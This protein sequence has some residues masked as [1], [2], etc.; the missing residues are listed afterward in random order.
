MNM[1]RNPFIFEGQVVSNDDPDQMGRVKVWIQA[2]DGEVFEVD[3]LPWAEYASML[4]GFTVEMPGGTDNTKNHSHA[5]YG[6]W[7]IPKMGATVY[8]FCLGGDPSRRVYFASS[9]RLH[10]NRSMPAGRNADGFG[11]PGPWG[12]AGDGNGTLIPIEPAFSNLRD[13]FQNKVTDSEAITRGTYE[14]MAAQ[15]LFDKDGKEGYSKTPLAGENYLDPQTYCFVTPGRHALIF[16]DDPKYARVRVKTAEGHQIILDDVNERIYV[17]TAK[18]KSWIEMDL[19]GHVHI[20]GN[21]NV[22]VRSGKD[23]NFTADG[24][25]NLEAGKGFN[26]KARG[27]DIRMATAKQL[28][29]HAVGAA[30]IAACGNI[31]IDG[32][33]AIKIAS[34]DDTDFKVGGDWTCNAERGVDFKYGEKLRFDGNLVHLSG[35]GSR[36]AKKAEC[37]KQPDSPS[38]VPGHEPWRRP[39]GEGQR[40]KNWK[41]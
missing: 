22:S 29:V 32:E 33:A 20:F 16:Q 31:N 10:R 24:N 2:L 12:D 11:K 23:I 19:D 18:G 21:S 37:P 1:S 34:A 6:M 26:L 15:P 35:A 9:W 4:S 17:S 5:A 25:I 14:R 13:Q 36:T 39:K 28:H 8:V 27:G 41:A 7:A 40:G 38:V 30:F 3:Q